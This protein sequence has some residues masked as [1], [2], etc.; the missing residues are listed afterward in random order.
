MPG[1]EQEAFWDV[2]WAAADEITTIQ[3]AVESFA[4]E[5]DGQAF[6]APAAFR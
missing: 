4:A 3:P 1:G 5:R 2:L 6:V